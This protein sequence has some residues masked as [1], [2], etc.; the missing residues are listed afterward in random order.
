[1]TTTVKNGNVQAKG[2]ENA[3]NRGMTAERRMQECSRLAQ[4]P[5]HDV[6]QGAGTQECS[7]LD[8]QDGKHRKSAGQGTRER[9]QGLDL[10]P[11]NRKPT[12]PGTR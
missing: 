12:G 3:V 2:R 9:R 8:D 1:M 10:D 6:H 4:G 11:K 5:W 7:Q